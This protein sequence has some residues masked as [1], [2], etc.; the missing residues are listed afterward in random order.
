MNLE[1]RLFINVIPGKT[2]LDRLSGATKVRLFFALIILLAATWDFRILFPVFVVSL[3]GLVSIKPNWKVVGSLMAFIIAVNLFNLFLIWVV[4]PDYGRDIVGGSTVLFTL[5]S[6]YILSAETLWYFLIRFTKF[7]ATFLVS[8]TFIQAITPSEIA[9]GLYS[10]KVPYKIA[11]IVSIAFRY[12]PDISRDFADI[13]VSMQ[14]RGMELDPKKT[15]LFTRLKQNVLIL[16]PLI[17]ISFERVGNIANAMDLRGYGRGKTRTY[18]SEH[19]ETR[20]DRLMKVIYILL[21]L[22]VLAV[23]FC[24]IFF[25]PEFQV[26]APW[27]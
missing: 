25:P 27:I 21:Y 7:M 12:I 24:R 11:T 14:A 22:A 20:N 3:I 18:Y 2:F 6:R 8:L 4:T 17:I 16:C 10:I 9:A 1:K 26:W 13:K 19:G 15:G 23:I 5:T